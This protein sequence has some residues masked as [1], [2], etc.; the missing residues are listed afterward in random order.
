[1]GGDDVEFEAMSP[2][3]SG[4]VLVGLGHQHGERRPCRRSPRHPPRRPPAAIAARCDAHDP[5][6]AAVT[7]GSRALDRGTPPTHSRPR[8]GRGSY[9]PHRRSR[10]AGR[11]GRGAR[12]WRRTDGYSQ[13]RPGHVRRA[14]RC[15]CS[16]AR[17]RDAGPIPPSV[18][19]SENLSLLPVASRLKLLVVFNLRDTHER[20]RVR[21]RAACRSW[22]P[23]LLHV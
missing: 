14:C 17:Q 22:W 18:L 23:H 3:R 20:V 8:H 1:M 6:I 5:S 16:G 19:A 2:E 4:A 10:R 9:D 13:E 7:G 21:L 12:C 15:H 11:G